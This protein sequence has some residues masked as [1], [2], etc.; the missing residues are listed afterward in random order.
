MHAS[1][2]S[3]RRRFDVGFDWGIAMRI[4]A[5]R[6][7]VQ[8]TGRSGAFLVMAVDRDRQ[9]A[10]LIPTDGGQGLEE[11]VPFASILPFE[12]SSPHG[13]HKL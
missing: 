6:E 7:R 11:D 10:D 5:V 3:D 8:V 2:R 12:E 13:R 1:I 4:P 9:V